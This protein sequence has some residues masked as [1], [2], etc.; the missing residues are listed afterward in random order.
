[1]SQKTV[2]APDCSTT[3]ADATYV[4]A[5]TTTSSP[6]RDAEHR[7]RQVQSGRARGRRECVLGPGELPKQ[8][9]ELGHLRPLHDPTG[10]ER[11]H[12]RLGLLLPKNGRV[13][14]MFILV[15]IDPSIAASPGSG[16]QQVRDRL[17]VDV[18]QTR[19]GTERAQNF[20]AERPR[21]DDQVR[22][23]VGQQPGA[24]LDLNARGR[25]EQ[26]GEQ[27]IVVE[28]PQR[29]QA[30]GEQRL[31]V[32]EAAGAKMPT[33]APRSR[34][35]R[36][37]SRMRSRFPAARATNDPGSGGG[38]AGPSAPSARAQTECRAP[39][40]P[41]ARCSRRGRPPASRRPRG[42]FR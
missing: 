33:R 41:P 38:E 22:R 10:L 21:D 12:H 34:R 24:R 35:S 26:A 16:R 30:V 20:C 31:V 37:W 18:V 36:R 2:V 42:S 27:R 19:L 40:T 11:R 17:N 1:M 6:G 39:A 8:A 28:G 13:I 14:P 32:D 15:S 7:E 9:L 23:R 3:L 29:R 25:I 5:G 4:N